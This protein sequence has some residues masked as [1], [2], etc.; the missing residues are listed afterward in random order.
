MLQTLKNAF[1]IPELRSKLVFTMVIVLIYRLGAVIPVPFINSTMMASLMAAS[2]G[3]IFQYLNLLS[4]DAFSKATL[5]ALSVSP[6]I[7]ASIVMQLLTVAIPALERLSKEGDEGRKKITTYT[8]YLTVV[9]GLITSYGYYMVIKNLHN[10]NNGGV[11]T[12]M[13]LKPFGMI[14]IIAC[15]CAGTALVMWLAEK[16]NENGIGNGISIILFANIV[17]SLPVMIGSLGYRFV[18]GI[19]SLFKTEWVGLLDILFVL[20]SIVIT[21]AIVFLVVFVTQ[22]ERKIPIQYAKRVVGRKMYGGQNT[23]L[24]IKLNMTGVMPIIFANSIVS[25]PATIIAFFNIKK[26]GIWDRIARTLSPSSWVYA[27]VLFMLIIG[28]SYFYITISFNPIEV[29]NNLKKNGGFI[30]GI[31]PG[32][33]PS[34]YISKILSKITFIGGL[35]LGFVAIF[36]IVLNMVSGGNVAALVFG[37]SSLLIVVGV[38]LETT[39]EIEAQMTMRHYKG[40]LD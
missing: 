35:F 14:V 33:P 21:V 8:R 7:T 1:K 22:S 30:P 12:R 27:V 29:S 20:L 32:K 37:G 39:R 6:Y 11:L 2:E 10:Q 28:F 25:L 31:R 15:Y 16:I 23:T 24:P 38:A 19:K 4:G 17:S 34:D 9:L 40:F 5:F 26:G 3:S 36:P 18:G 13:G